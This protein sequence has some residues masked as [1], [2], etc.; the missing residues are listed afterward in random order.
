MTKD[1]KHLILIGDHKQLRPKT[2]D[3]LVGKNFNLKISL[4]ERLVNI[5]GNC[6]Q[7]TRQHR[8]RPDIAKL[9][10]PTIYGQLENDESVSEYPDVKGIEKN[11]FF[12]NHKFPESFIEPV[13]YYNKHEVKFIIA[14]AMYLVQQG[15]ATTDITVL[16]TYSAQVIEL[17]KVCRFIIIMCIN[18]SNQKKYFKN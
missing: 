11:V 7:L 12:V 2:S 18:L 3:H 13:G 8:M 4:F 16:S 5:K 15:Y 10:S 6:N 14:L 9:I 1:T 17:K